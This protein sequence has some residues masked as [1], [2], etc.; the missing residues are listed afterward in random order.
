MKPVFIYIYFMRFQIRLLLLVALV[1]FAGCDNDK[2]PFREYKTKYIV[3]VLVDG[4]RYSET[5]GDASHQYIPFL[6]DSMA[7]EGVVN[8][9]FYNHGITNTVN[10]HAAVTTGE[11]DD[12]DNTGLDYPKKHSFFQDWIS[13]HNSIYQSAWIVAS[14]DKLAVL[15]NTDEPNWK[16]HYL[17]MID[18]GV[19]GWGSGYREDSVTYVNA[20]NVIQTK[21]PRLLLINFKDPDYYGHAGDWNMY[22]Q[23]IVKTDSYINSI[24]SAI[25]ADPEMANKTTLF[26]TNDHGRQTSDYT[27]HGDGCEGCRHIMF[28][29]VGPDFKKG[30]VV[31]TPRSL[32]DIHATISELM[33]L[34]NSSDGEVMSEL[35][36]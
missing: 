23:G 21:T 20:L 10:G 36:N 15:G 13:Q 30:G 32:I 34:Q 28:F 12:L 8:S 16:N 11:Y 33:H 31:S 4:A 29:A 25:Q 3:I 9:T 22:C 26:V 35:F 19:S 2:V 5:W 7:Q 24:W 14:K 17:P 27:G 1:S 6:A 18:C